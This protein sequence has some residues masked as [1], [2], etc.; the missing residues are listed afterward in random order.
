MA[1][2]VSKPNLEVPNRGLLTVSLMLSTT[3]Q[4]LDTTIANVA[5]P[6]MQGSLSASQDQ[7]AWVLTSYIVAAAIATPLSG[8]LGDR[9]GRKAVV[10][11]SVIGFTVA[12]ALCGMATG[13]GEIVVFRFI[14]GLFGAALV[15]MAQSILLD[16]NPKEK[17]GQAMAIWGAGIMVAPIL[18]PTLG[19]WITDHYSW[20]WVFYINMPV[21]V[22]AF[23]GTQL[24]MPGG[25]G[26][27]HR[28]FD[29]KGFALLS[30]G[31]AS[32]QLMLDRGQQQ[33]W[34]SSPEI[35]IEGAVA[36]CC[37]WVFGVYVTMAKHPFLQPVLLKDRN[38]ASGLLFMTIL[39]MILMST[40]ALLPPL[41]QGLMQYTAFG[42]GWLMMPRGAATMV[43]MLIVG[44]LTGKL[45]SRLMLFF[46]FAMMALAQWQMASYALGMDDR[47][48]IISSLVQGCGM[49][50]IFPP[51]TA[52][53]FVTLAPQFRNEGTAVF[54][55]VRNV[56]GS[57]GISFAE[58]FLVQK[59][60]I[61]HADLATHVT[62][63]AQAFHLPIISQFWN[64]N[65]TAGLA[66]IN[67]EV[68]RQAAM[69]GY[70][71]VF[72]LMLILTVACLPFIFLL[73]KGAAIPGGAVSQP[74]VALD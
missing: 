55:L 5:L 15:P 10:Q 17:I 53:A 28:P 35:V 12:S 52:I 11:I 3:M 21:G 74:V 44:R 42:A 61:S 58:S 43:A 34:F 27:R 47:L 73:R 26:G 33:D 63:F 40:M 39:G 2:A 60:Q 37:F 29:F 24:F 45:D 62:P 22:L 19:G 14:Q 46:G 16:I 13:L 54:N 4:M 6:H 1:A 18:G 71:D 31:I 48:I 65:S 8:W 51:L 7:I 38:F 9:F 64:L 66:A 69:I 25:E 67:A 50:F 72:K 68:T 70:V 57:I 30:I 20:R 56:A 41:L 59:T 36:L 23:F 32:L 49:G